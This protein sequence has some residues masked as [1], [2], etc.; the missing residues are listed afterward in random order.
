MEVPMAD[1]VFVDNNYF[2]SADK[3]IIPVINHGGNNSAPN[4]IET[5]KGVQL[6]KEKSAKFATDIK[7]LGAYIY[8]SR[9]DTSG[10]TKRSVANEKELVEELKKRGFKVIIPGKHTLAEQ[11]KMF[12]EAKVIMGPHGAGLTNLLF[13]D[14]FKALIELFP[15]NFQCNCFLKLSQINNAKEYHGLAFYSVEPPTADNVQGKNVDFIVDIPK[16]L[17]IVDKVIEKY[18]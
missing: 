13:A 4:K 10:K 3:V 11:V 7:P 14:N 8:V 5:M 15:E 6:L 12:K 17:E 18:K 16:T 2:Y 1:R 9:A